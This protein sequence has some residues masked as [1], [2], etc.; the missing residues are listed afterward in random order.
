MMEWPGGDELDAAIQRL[1]RYYKA[2]PEATVICGNHSRL[3]RRKA[4][5]GGIPKKWIKITLMFLEV[6]KWEFTDV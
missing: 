4:L 6:P 2:F 3:V 5:S 1:G